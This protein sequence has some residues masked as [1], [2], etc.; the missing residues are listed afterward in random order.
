MCYV[1]VNGNAMQI[2][3][4][5]R[6]S[7]NHGLILSSI[8]PLQLVDLLSVLVSKLIYGD[9]TKYGLERPSEGPIIRRVRDGKYPVIDVGTFKKIKSGEIQVLF[10]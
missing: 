5:P 10:S 7:V 2:H 9:I 1:L 3:I 4:L 8:I 6:W